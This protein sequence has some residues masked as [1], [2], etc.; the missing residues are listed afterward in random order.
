MRVEQ[1]NAQ[2]VV[3]QFSDPLRERQNLE[4]L[5]NIAGLSSLEFEIK[6][7]EVRVFPPVRQTG[8]KEVTIEAGIRNIL[9]YRM[10]QRGVF[11]VQF[12]QEKPAVKFAGKGSV[13]P[14][15]D[16]RGC[17]AHACKTRRPLSL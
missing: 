11:S 1:G 12:E 2:S 6:D 15:T 3:V 10:G 16:G 8:S 17:H 14:A 7:N 4:G 5:I 13:L 9:D